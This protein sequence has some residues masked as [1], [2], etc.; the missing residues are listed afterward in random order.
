MAEQVLMVPDFSQLPRAGSSE[1]ESDGL[2][3]I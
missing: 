2:L 1:N 3:E